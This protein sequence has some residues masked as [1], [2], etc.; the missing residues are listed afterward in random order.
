MYKVYSFL[1]SSFLVC[2]FSM[3]SFCLIDALPFVFFY[4]PELLLV[5]SLCYFPGSCFILSISLQTLSATA[6]YIWIDLY[7]KTFT[8]RQ[9]KKKKPQSIG[10]CIYQV[11]SSVY[12]L[13]F[14]YVLLYFFF[15][16][17]IV[18]VFNEYTY[19]KLS[20]CT[21]CDLWLSM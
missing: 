2:N 15:F 6:R 11:Y 4:L 14:C 21:I 7:E 20:L 3:A 8:D 9:K 19:D 18:N 17:F 16:S 10:S 5:C 13:V 1:S 12:Y